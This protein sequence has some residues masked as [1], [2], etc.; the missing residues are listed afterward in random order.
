MTLT[1]REKMLIAVAAVFLLAVG[2]YFLSGSLGNMLRSAE[3]REK[4]YEKQIAELQRLGQEFAFLTSLRSS[5]TEQSLDGMVPFVE[6]MLSTRGIRE[7]AELSSNDATVEN[8]YLRRTVT[9]SFREVTPGSVLE[10]IGD[11]EASPALYRLESFRSNE[12]LKKPGFYRI[13]LTIS[14]YQKKGE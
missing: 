7:I 12:I 6:A 5:S 3:D 13:A 10:F 11:I 1:R 14:A 8:L 2:L 9:V 4:E